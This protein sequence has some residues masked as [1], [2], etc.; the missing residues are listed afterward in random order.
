MSLETP[1]VKN[2]SDN[3]ISQIEAS[4]NQK[5]PLLPKSFIR[6]LAKALSGVFILLY[7]YCGFIFLQMFI[8][9]ATSSNTEVNGRVINPL[10]EWGKLVGVGSPKS[11][12]SAELVISIQVDNQVGSIDSQTQLIGAINGVTYLLVNTVA[13][14]NSTVQGTIKAVQDQQNGRGAGTIGNLSAG[15][16][17][18]FVNPLANIKRE[19]TV[20]GQS[21]TGANAEDIEVY[22]QRVMDRWQKPPRGGAYADYEIWGEETEGIVNIYPYTSECPGQVDVYVEAT[23]ESSG[24][25][26]GIPTLAQLQSV[27]DFINYDEDGLATRR[28]A[29]AL[30]NTFAIT[31]ASFDIRVV[32]LSVENL[33]DVQESIENALVEYFKSREPYIVG[34]SIPPRN[35]RITKVALS[36]IINDIV[37]ANNGFFSGVF[38][39]K[40]GSSTSLYTLETGE[41]AKLGTVSFL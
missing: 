35:D 34:L 20:I 12:T 28:P 9:Y 32:G 4:I 11:A 33:S 26:D 22:R 18:S 14:D 8:K 15:D 27:L 37:N 41:K 1:S 21:I 40:D 23:A 38:I 10:I 6:V 36:G 31:R 5:I 3:L 30:V 19:A 25:A 17:V 2:I 39:E 13:L 24:N 16:I 7:K 29:N